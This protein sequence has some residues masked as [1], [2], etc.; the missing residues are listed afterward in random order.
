VYSMVG[1]KWPFVI[2]G[3][4]LILASIMIFSYMS[5]SNVKSI[6]PAGLQRCDDGCIPT[7]ARCSS[8]GS[9]C[10]ESVTENTICNSCSDDKKMCG[11]FCIP[12]SQKCCIAGQ[13]EM[14]TSDPIKI[15]V[16]D[17]GGEITAAPDIVTTEVT[18]DSAVCT[19]AGNNGYL[20]KYNAVSSGKA[21][22]PVGTRFYLDGSGQRPLGYITDCGDWTMVTKNMYP[23]NYYC[24][25]MQGE[26]SFTSWVAEDSVDLPGSYEAGEIKPN[27]N[28]GSS[29]HKYGQSKIIDCP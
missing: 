22:G 12:K 27:I 6:C 4:V 20:T 26:V 13:C 25:R 11:M 24:Q 18:I 3:V 2:G 14:T 16:G 19:I 17:S 9:Y 10:L 1:I 5:D 23:E 29:D 8:G 15:D 7:N 21:Q 28:S